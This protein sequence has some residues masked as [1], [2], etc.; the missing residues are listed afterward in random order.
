MPFLGGTGSHARR[1]V[2]LTL[3]FVA[4][5]LAVLP[6][7]PA[8][9]ADRN[10]AVRF[11]VNDTG[12]I[13]IVGNTVMTCQTAASGCA[14]ARTAGPSSVANSALNNNAYSMVYVDVDA[15]ATTFNSSQSTLDLPTGA[16]VLFAGLYWGGEVTAGSGGT[17]APS[18]AARGTVRLRAPG[19][20]AY[21]TITATTVDDGA[22]IYQGFA[23]VTSRVAAAGKGT[24]TLA[25]LQ[26]GT[27]AD[28]L[29]GWSLVVAYRDTSQP[30]R[31][32]SVFDGL[33]SINGSSSGTIN[34]SG[35]TTPPAGAVNAT[36]GFVNYEGDLGLV[37]DGAS[38]NGIP[39][40]DAQHPAAN[41]FDSRSSRNGVLRTGNSPSYDNNL[42]FEHSMLSVGNT[43]IGNGATSATIGLTTAGDVY[44][45]GVVTLATELYAP[46]INQTKT[47]VDLNGGLVQQGDTLRYT[48]SG[49][50]AGQDG[51]AG[52]VLRDP[53]PADTGYVPGSIRV[54]QPGGTATPRTDA[55]GDDVAEYDATNDRVVARFGTGSNATAGG[56]IAPGGTY[57][58]VFDVVVDGPV[59]AVPGG[60]VVR[61][62]A[63][64]SYSSQSLGTALTTVST[65]DVTVAAPDLAITKTHSGTFVQ[66]GQATFTLGVSNVGPVASQGTVT[67][68]DTLPAGLT[69]ASAT[70]SGWTCTGSATFTCTRS[71][72]LAAGA[73]YPPITLTVN[74]TDTAPATVANTATVSGGGDSPDDNNSVVD[75]VP[76]VAVTDLSISKTADV[77]TAPVGGNVTYSLTITNNGPSR[78]TGSTVVDTLPA[79]MSFVSA[80]AGCVSTPSASTV[81]CTV[82]ALA[83]GASTTV[84]VTT[85]PD[86]GTAGRSL[87]NSASIMANESDPTSGNNNA[88]STIQ[89]RPVDLAITSTIQGNPATLVPG[90]AYTW[91]LDVSNLGTSPA[92]DSVVRFAVPADLVVDAASFDPRCVL[93]DGDVVCTLGTVGPGASIVPI[94]VKGSVSLGTRSTTIDTNAVVSTSEPEADH[95]N[96]AAATS[97]PVTNVVDLRVTVVATPTSVGAGDT[98][99]LTS[100]VSNAGPGTPT[101]PVLTVVIPDGTTFVSAD[102][103]CTYADA[104]RTVTCTLD[105]AALEPGESVVRSLVVTV[106]PRPVDPLTATAVVTTPNDA[107]LTNNTSTVVVPVL[108]YSGLSIVKTIDRPQATPGETVTYTLTVSN[109][110]PA[111]ARDVVVTDALPAGTT[112]AAANAAGGTCTHAGPDVSCDLG[113]VAAGTT[114][115]V[116][117]A[118]TVDPV[119]ASPSGLGHQLDVTKVETHLAAPAASTATASA[120]CPA[121]YVAT[122]GSVRIDAVDQGNSL[123]DVLVLRGSATADGNGWTGTIRNTT[124]GQAQAKVLVVCTTATTTTDDGHQHAVLVS[125]PHPTST[126]WTAGTWTAD[127]SCGVGQVAVAPGFTFTSGEGVVRT[128]QRAGTGWHF[129][130]DVPESASATF[131]IRCLSSSVDTA[132]GHTHDLGLVQLSNTVTVPSGQTVQVALTCG[133]QAKGIVASYDVDPGLLSLGNDPQPKTRV[134]KFNNPTSATLTARI[135][136]LCLDTRTG[137]A[138][139]VSS[140]TNTAHVAT[141]SQDATTDDDS[142][143]ATFTATA[144]SGPVTPRFSVA[145]PTA[146]VIGV[147]ARTRLVVPIRTAATQRLTMRVVLLRRVPG[148]ALRRGAVVASQAVT[149]RAG[150]HD[151]RLV[152]RKRATT[153]VSIGRVARVRVVVL[154]RD[155]HREVRIV[156]LR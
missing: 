72:V 16:T 40:S 44:A 68:S 5:L 118:A 19:A 63:T 78:S 96:N 62:T 51:A 139:A 97:T 146:R 50:N 20:A 107:D 98:L 120:S 36:I 109:A 82:G 153:P 57:T 110:G 122:D 3:S 27:G 99:T 145:A 115:V 21:S 91:R 35:F 141:S 28:R 9:A 43:Y 42:G 23:D 104:T 133:E 142:S 94:L 93:D 116:T 41:F 39:L 74:V 71:D 114:R 127:L 38:L 124:S 34:V 117:I 14:A 64:A 65:A 69:F 89:V 80:D 54:T 70:G 60:T 128:S 135:G 37:G 131:D 100:T 56:T 58:L 10:F 86:L 108:A 22:I 147:G 111:S 18:A 132:A 92:A 140:I 11:S 8:A 112:Y 79:G 119:A 90:Q 149:A 143:S 77:P 130:V 123:A 102:P 73:A 67:V 156:R 148:T 30:A 76:T 154:S 129:V 29:G 75:S 95:G 7:T 81:T 4:T 150:R 31:N 134:F 144:G 126:T 101:N 87:T 85:R 2:L 61:N 47:V 6:A 113:T 55:A 25:N 46:R 45:P 32:L 83:S 17:A 103:G 152:V 12:D 13:D 84:Q 155:G 136:L 138:L 1:R 66:G 125:A 105:P 48:V 121:G 33:R 15:D 53:V 26:T 151:I 24:Y 88:T 137:P 59:P 49:T 106:G 52:F